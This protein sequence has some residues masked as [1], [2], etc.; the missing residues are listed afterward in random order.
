MNI[1]THFY[2]FFL[3]SI[4]QLIHYFITIYNFYDINKTY[5]LIFLLIKL[6]I[7]DK[8]INTCI[9]KRIIIRMTSI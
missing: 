5:F 1:F 8:K 9:M 3:I 7:K 2:D 4:F 6:K